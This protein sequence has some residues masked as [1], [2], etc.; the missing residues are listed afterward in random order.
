MSAPLT[1]ALHDRAAP[2]FLL[3]FLPFACGYFLSLSYRN[4]NGVA[5]PQLVAE[6]S[7]TPSDLGLLTSAYF[8]TF[9]LAQPVLGVLLDRFG[10]RRVNAVLMTVA[11][12]G[13]LAFAYA[14]TRLGLTLARATIGLGCAMALMATFKQMADWLPREKLPFANGLALAMGGLGALFASRPAEWLLS[15]TTWRTLFIGLA[16][17]TLLVAA[18]LWWGAPDR[19]RSNANQQPFSWRQEA[20]YI[21]TILSPARFWVAAFC[22]SVYVAV[23]YSWQGVW[24]SSWLR[25][26][27]G[28][29]NAEAAN[30]LIGVAIALIVGPLLAGSLAGRARARGADEWQLVA[31]MCGV[32]VTVTAVIT[33]LSGWVSGWIWI[34]FAMTSIAPN[35]LF[36]IL[37]GTYSSDMTGR[38]N[39]WLNCIM[40]SFAF[41]A[42]WGIG[43]IIAQFPATAT[44]YDRRGYTAALVTLLV[45]QLLALATLIAWRAR[46]RR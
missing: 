10:P 6:F 24:I 25:D 46:Q 44:G 27:K 38:V 14:E 18:F 41:L 19:G 2:S 12:S 21:R 32:A 13:G 33:L 4:I 9:S 30:V 43:V 28:H 7:L 17:V 34:I 1:P 20:T 40:F 36:A 15:L 31:R 22:C 8:L 16:G 26:F 29:S 23:F 5:T 11:A 42:Q 45:L 37:A 35:V 39:T 3:I